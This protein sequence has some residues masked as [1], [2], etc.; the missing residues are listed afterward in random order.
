MFP[1]EPGP[2]RAQ[3]IVNAEIAGVKGQEPLAARAATVLD[4]DATGGLA[5][6][7]RARVVHARALRD[8]AKKNA[9][10]DRVLADVDACA[11]SELPY[12]QACRVAAVEAALTR[13]MVDVARRMWPD[14]DADLP[15]AKRLTGSDRAPTTTP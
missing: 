10:L 8:A 1:S 11:K 6:Q 4:D 15:L 2:A 13:G 14:P 7:M 5:G 3:A 9:E 12:E